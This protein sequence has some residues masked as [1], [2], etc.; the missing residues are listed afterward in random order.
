MLSRSKFSNARASQR[1]VQSRRQG[2]ATASR[3][4]P[5]DTRCVRSAGER[6]FWLGPARPVPS[7][8][9]QTTIRGSG[10]STLGGSGSSGQCHGP[11]QQS[12]HPRTQGTS[13]ASK[14][15]CD[16]VIPD[17]LAPNAGVL[18][19]MHESH[20][21]AHVHMHTTG[22]LPK[23]TGNQPPCFREADHQGRH[24]GQHML[25]VHLVCFQNFLY[26]ANQLLWTQYHEELKRKA[27]LAVKTQRSLVGAGPSPPSHSRPTR[28]GVET[29]DTL[30]LPTLQRPVRVGGNSL[31]VQTG[32]APSAESPGLTLPGPGSTGLAGSRS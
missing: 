29:V 20:T 12:A 23:H 22:V 5:A 21:H 4:H 30:C 18:L 32:T 15:V 28:R 9:D 27:P 11:A 14:D 13:R 24:T 2:P 6:A 3:R 1:A 16:T 26:M 31:V 17:G 10:T 8:R 25:P 7:S 19:T